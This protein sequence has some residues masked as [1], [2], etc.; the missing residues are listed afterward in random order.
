MDEANV[1]R[2][3]GEQSTAEKNWQT[4]NVFLRISVLVC[5]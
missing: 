1:A 3:K 5:G 2:L 4:W